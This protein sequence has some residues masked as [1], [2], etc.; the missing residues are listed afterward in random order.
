MDLR[1]LTQRGLLILLDTLQETNISPKNGILKM[2]FLFPRWDMLIPWR[3]YSFF[4][5]CFGTL[6]ELRIFEEQRLKEKEEEMKKLRHF[7]A[8]VHEV[9]PQSLGPVRVSCPGVGHLPIKISWVPVREFSRE[10]QIL[11]KVSFADKFLSFN[12]QREEKL[13]CGQ[14]K[15][16]WETSELR[17]FKNAKTSV[18]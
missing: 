3:V 1:F 18:K 16:G 10:V 15:F 13:G 12:S 11:W 14:R 4:P 5:A 9:L 2:I 7:V 8:F 17:T 6:E